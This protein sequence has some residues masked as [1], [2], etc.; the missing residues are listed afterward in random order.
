M[1]Y[2]GIERPSYTP[3]LI[4]SLKDDEV[5]VF[6]SNLEGIHGGGAAYTAYMKFGAVMGYGVG[7]RGQSYAIPTMQGGLD[8]I[9]PYVDDFIAF[10][11][12][13]PELFFYVTRI[14]CGIAGFKDKEIAPL[15]AEAVELE[16]V[17]LPKS[18]M[19]GTLAIATEPERIIKIFSI[20]D[21]LIEACHL[22]LRE[23]LHINYRPGPPNSW[24]L[25]SVIASGFM[26]QHTELCQKVP[27]FGFLGKSEKKGCSFYCIETLDSLTESEIQDFNLALKGNS[28]SQIVLLIRTKNLL[29]ISAQGNHIYVLDCNLPEQKPLHSILNLFMQLQ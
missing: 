13:H 2:N 24:P 8:T 27:V 5:F 11:R 17:C 14:G 23:C 3:D 1:K 15:F 18:F 25:G 10:V 26:E 4:S 28:D 9:K 19:T 7:L 22:L 21:N 20:E 12:E 29:T 6:G 16:N